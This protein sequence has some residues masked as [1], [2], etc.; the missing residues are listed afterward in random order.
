MWNLFIVNNK[1]IRTTSLLF[2]CLYHCQLRTDFTNCSGVSIVDFEQ[3]N[4]N[5][6]KNNNITVGFYLVYKVHCSAASSEPA[7]SKKYYFKNIN[8]NVSLTT[9]IKFQ[10]FRWN[11]LKYINN[12]PSIHFLTKQPLVFCKHGN[13]F[14]LYVILSVLTGH[15]QVLCIKLHSFGGCQKSSENL[16]FSDYF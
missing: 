14:I 7:E 6:A 5:W 12:I 8:H 2:W 16:W 9:R 11:Y 1:E 4:A 3:V 10:L 15:Q 13:F